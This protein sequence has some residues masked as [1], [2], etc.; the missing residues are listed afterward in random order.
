[1]DR[2]IMQPSLQEHGNLFKRET[3]KNNVKNF[4]SDAG[5]MNNVCKLC[6]FLAP[7]LDILWHIERKLYYAE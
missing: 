3:W 7:Q 2:I 5:V 4:Y 1:M 6:C